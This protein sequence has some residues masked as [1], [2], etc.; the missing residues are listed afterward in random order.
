MDG[1][2]R[3]AHYM[4][5]IEREGEQPIPII[6]RDNEIID[7]AGIRKTEAGRDHSL[8]HQALPDRSRLLLPDYEGRLQ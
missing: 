2:D 6:G 8:I 7:G 3:P 5:T 1:G 4:D